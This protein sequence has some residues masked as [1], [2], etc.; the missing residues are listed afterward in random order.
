MAGSSF[1]AAL[2]ST[3][4]SEV[5]GRLGGTVR[6]GHAPAHAQELF[7]D[8]SPSLADVVRDMNKWS[9]NVIARQLL[10]TL[11]S[12]LPFAKAQMRLCSKKRPTMDLTRMFSDRA[13]TPG[14]RQQMPRTISS[15]VTPALLA[16]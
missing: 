13:G 15:I 1:G 2:V 7:S 14:R 5:G 6:A 4:W 3:L 9:S 10:A 8:D 11:G 16:A 12:A